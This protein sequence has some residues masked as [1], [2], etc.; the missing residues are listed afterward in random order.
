[1]LLFLFEE[2][3]SISE[4]GIIMGY[5]P[6]EIKMVGESGQS[7]AGKI[8]SISCQLQLMAWFIL[9]FIIWLARGANHMTKERLTP[10]KQGIYDYNQELIL[11]FI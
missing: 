3:L 7:Q 6:S 4:T 1:M 8:A 5:W 11:N 2:L 10:K 9:Q